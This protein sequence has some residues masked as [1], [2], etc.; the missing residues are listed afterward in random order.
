MPSADQLSFSTISCVTVPGADGTPALVPYP[1]QRLVPAVAAAGFTRIG[2]DWFTIREA[3]RTGADLARLIEDNGLVPSELCAMGIGEDPAPD[4]RVARS[5]A[6]RCGQLGIPVCVLASTPP[7]SDALCARVAAIAGIF[8]AA[9]TRVG[10]EFMPYSGVRTLAEARILNERVGCGIVLDTLHLLRS[11]CAPAELDTLEATDIACV[12]LADGPARPAGSLAEESRSRR[13]L[14]GT[15]A[16]RF[17]E[18]SAVLDRIGYVG[19]I[20]IEV[21]SATLR[22]LPPETMARTFRA[23]CLPYVASG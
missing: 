5:M 19:P 8:G 17:A 11:G 13:L 10:V 16:V 9:G 15:G 14:P 23:A 2:L 18:F 21:L 4:E 6:R 22:T 12:Q 1:V 7:L 3:E 20:G